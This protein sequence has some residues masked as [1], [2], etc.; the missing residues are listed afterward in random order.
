[1]GDDWRLCPFFGGFDIIMPS[2][3]IQKSTH[4]V[5]RDDR[6]KGLGPLL[7]GAYNVMRRPMIYDFRRN[8]KCLRRQVYNMCMRIVYARV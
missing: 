3:P 8:A 6:E 1:M 7:L 4:T 5:G 2:V